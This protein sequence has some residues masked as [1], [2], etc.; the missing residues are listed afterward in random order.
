MYWAH[1]QVSPIFVIIFSDAFQKSFELLKGKRGTCCQSFIVFI[2]DG[3]DTD[4][5]KVR[6]EK[7]YHT[8]S[9]Y[10]AGE[11]CKYDWNI[12]WDNV[13]TWNTQQV[14]NGLFQI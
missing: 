11:K 12:V 8:R 13:K 14:G 4:G 2:T 10:V 3:Q 9:G 6:C 5:D 1:A 7:G